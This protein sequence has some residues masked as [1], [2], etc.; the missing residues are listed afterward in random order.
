MSLCFLL[1]NIGEDLRANWQYS[2]SHNLF[3]TENVGALYLSHGFSTDHPLV[4][5]IRII[6]NIT[7]VTTWSPGMLQNID[8][9]QAK[10]IKQRDKKVLKITRIIDTPTEYKNAQ[11]RFRAVNDK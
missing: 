3:T 5:L 7:L 9:L 11:G 8:I 4:F 2:E 1:G 6:F 10:I